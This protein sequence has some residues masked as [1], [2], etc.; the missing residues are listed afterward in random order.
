MNIRLLFVILFF[1]C[2]EITGVQC[3][4][5]KQCWLPFKTW[6]QKKV[7]EAQAL[8][9][10]SRQE[11]K[12]AGSDEKDVARR[13]LAQ[14]ETSLIIA[15]DLS[16]NDYF[17]LYVTPLF[18]D[19]RQALLQAARHLSAQDTADIMGAY[20]KTLKNT[21]LDE[22]GI[23]KEPPRVTPTNS[24]TLGKSCF[25]TKILKLALTKFYETSYFPRT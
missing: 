19:N 14:A 5:L 13:R 22:E 25:L 3:F 9:R 2:V 24:R 7:D 12:R 16:A 23:L 11:M 15:H 1:V 6:R 8:V 21:D 17:L 20:Q 18:K 10:E 4:D